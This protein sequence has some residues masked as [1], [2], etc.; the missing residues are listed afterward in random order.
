MVVISVQIRNFDSA[1]NLILATKHCTTFVL[2]QGQSVQTDLLS[3][4]IST[5]ICEN[6]YTCS[7]TKSGIKYPLEV[8]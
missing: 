5:T 7:M 3:G 2:N 6:Q 1:L 8:V 4:Q